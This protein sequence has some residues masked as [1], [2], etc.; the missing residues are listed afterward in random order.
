MMTVT[1]SARRTV[2][3]SEFKKQP[4]KIQAIKYDYKRG[5]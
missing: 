5:V 1:S 4:V 3:M 2:P